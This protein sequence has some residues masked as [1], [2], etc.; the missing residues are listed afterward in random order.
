M[1]IYS[2][3]TPAGGKHQTGFREWATYSTCTMQP[4]E[5]WY[6]SPERNDLPAYRR[7][8]WHKR[9]AAALA[10]SVFGDLFKADRSLAITTDLLSFSHAPRAARAQIVVVLVLR[11]S[12]ISACTNSSSKLFVRGV[13]GVTKYLFSVEV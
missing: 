11:E 3:H 10:L 1:H 5:Q 6:F 7:P 2:L 4:F 9:G 8:R 12:R 13:N